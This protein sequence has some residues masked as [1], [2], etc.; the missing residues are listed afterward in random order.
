VQQL[1]RS[2]FGELTDLERVTRQASRSTLE[3]DQ[4]RAR[5]ADL[6]RRCRELPHPAAMLVLNEA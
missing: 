1:A 6:M 3:V 4:A 5:V 2:V